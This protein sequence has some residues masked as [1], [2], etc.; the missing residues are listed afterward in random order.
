MATR[1]GWVL[2]VDIRKFFDTLDHRHIQSM[3]SQRVRDGVVKRLIGKWLNAGV[4]VDGSLERPASGSPQGGVVSPLLAN[5][6]LHEVLDK[7][8]E[9]EVKPRL[10]GRVQLIRFADD[11]VM[12][13]T[14]EADARKVEEVLPKRFEKYGLTLHP[15]KTRLIPFKSPAR[16]GGNGDGPGSFDLL[17]FTH[18]WTRS[19]KGNWVVRRTTAKGRFTRGIRRIAEWCKT[20]RHRPVAEQRRSLNQKLRGHYGYYG[21]TGNSYALRRFRFEVLKVWHKWLSRRSQIPM[22]W[23]RFNEVLQTQPIVPARAVHSVL[24]LAANP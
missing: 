24:R 9:A 20:Y 4:M 13:F 18:F 5:I 6:Y 11:A 16:G 7:W 22:S 1:G 3:L 21:I 14:H 10:L 19:R 2:E 12:L 23:Q 17:G 8:V 15:E